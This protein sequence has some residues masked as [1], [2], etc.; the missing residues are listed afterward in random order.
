M[1]SRAAGRKIAFLLFTTGA[2][3]FADGAVS[4]VS[5]FKDFMPRYPMQG[6]GHFYQLEPFIPE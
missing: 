3:I 2:L 5:Q 1:N 6:A 4:A